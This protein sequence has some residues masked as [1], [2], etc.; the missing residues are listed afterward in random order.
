M[1]ATSYRIMLNMY[2]VYSGCGHNGQNRKYFNSIDI[3]GLWRTAHMGM[4]ISNGRVNS[5]QYE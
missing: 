2:N 3:C 4:N 5:K 1:T